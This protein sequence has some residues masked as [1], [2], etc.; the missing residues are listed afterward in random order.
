MDDRKAI[1][2][3]L[4]AEVIKEKLIEEEGKLF[5]LSERD[6]R[7]I[8]QKLSNKSY[9][10]GRYE[11]RKTGKKSTSGK[12]IIETITIQ[13]ILN[14]EKNLYGIIKLND[15]FY[16]INDLIGKGSF[17]EAKL[18]QDLVT[19]DWYVI[20]VQEASIINIPARKLGEKK[21]ESNEEKVKEIVSK[22]LKAKQLKEK[23]LREINAL[24]A[25]SLGTGNQ[26]PIERIFEK[27]E[28][29]MMT[30]TTEIFTQVQ[31][32]IVMKYIPGETMDNL[33][34]IS[35][36]LSPVDLFEI[37]AA[38]LR[39]LLRLKKANYY[40]C[41]LSPNNIKVQRNTMTVSLLD[42]GNSSPIAIYHTKKRQLQLAHSVEDYDEANKPAELPSPGTA[43][44][45]PREAVGRATE[46]SEVYSAGVI[47]AQLFGFAKMK[48]GRSVSLEWKE[49]DAIKDSD[50][51]KVY[52][53]IKKM[54][55]VATDDMIA[56]AMEKELPK[57]L[58]DT[59]PTND[60][61]FRLQLQR[62]IERNMQ[63]D[64][65]QKRVEQEVSATRPNIEKAAQKFEKFLENKLKREKVRVSV[66]KSGHAYFGFS[67]ALERKEKEAKQESSKTQKGS[68][69]N[70][71]KQ[72]TL[73][74]P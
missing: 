63:E 56:R 15:R 42:F 37:A 69:K 9:P 6:R 24:E 10:D 60:E 26:Q 53:Y 47:L 66:G 43:G 73:K 68:S 54:L 62:D 71:L 67:P 27:P 5:L 17:G 4:P 59:M 40:H 57:F 52:D 44:Y 3:D 12:N 2:S 72:L 31:Y 14:R 32:I 13:E 19:G 48:I 61:G 51:Q 20:K 38:F 34:K 22:N 29:N 74:K 65:I 46:K 36:Q 28:K 45:R 70:L 30:E 11:K 64:K 18:A 50:L 49:R 58:D 21:E 39:E 1:T 7:K 41:D 23:S 16:A 25:L 55:A 35:D 33:L 8:I